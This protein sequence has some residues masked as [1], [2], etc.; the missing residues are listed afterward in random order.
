M[1]KAQSLGGFSFTPEQIK[2]VLGSKEGQQ[3]LR[4]LNRDGGD[5]LRKAA[6]LVKAG[7]AQGAKHIMEP[8]M[9]D[10]QAAALAEEITRKQG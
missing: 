4:L 7:D 8:L 2:S 3:L 5:A 9:R 10:P 6:E 1:E